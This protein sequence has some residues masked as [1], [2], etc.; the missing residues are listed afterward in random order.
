MV[1]RMRARRCSIACNSSG[2]V[3]VVPWIAS[4]R[5]LV[6]LTMRLVDDTDGTGKVFI[7]PCASVLPEFL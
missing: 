6:A 2:A 1:P 5:Y 3:D 4:C 7:G